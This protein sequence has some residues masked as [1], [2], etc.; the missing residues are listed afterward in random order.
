VVGGRLG[1]SVPAH[2]AFGVFAAVKFQKLQV[3]A[4]SFFPYGDCR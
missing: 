2:H 4:W 1:Q 3:H